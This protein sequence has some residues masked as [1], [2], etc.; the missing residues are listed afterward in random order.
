MRDGRIVGF[1]V[2]RATMVLCTDGEFHAATAC[3]PLQPYGARL[4][5]TRRG[6]E[7]AADRYGAQVAEERA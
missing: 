1:I 2:V 7:R 3:G 5:K 4:Y 6:A